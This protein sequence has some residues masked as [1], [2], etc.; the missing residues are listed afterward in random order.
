MA[1]RIYTTYES[2]K[3]TDWSYLLVTTALHSHLESWLGIL[4]A[5][6]PMMGDL[7]K[8]C[9]P[10]IRSTLSKLKSGGGYFTDDSWSSKPSSNWK[11]LRKAKKTFEG[12][13]E[14]PATL[15][16]KIRPVTGP[17]TVTDVELGSFPDRNKI[18]ES[19]KNK[20]W[21]GFDFHV[22]SLSEEEHRETV[23][24]LDQGQARF[25]WS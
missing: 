19:N 25:R 15:P 1:W 11:P 2:T 17:R 24:P 14:D 4:A 16:L 21:R 12:I 3:T 13:N 22:D 10:I 8:S 5:N 18:D 23:S 9:S 7:M 20:I 6:L